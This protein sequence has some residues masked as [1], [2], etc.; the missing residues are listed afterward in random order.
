[1]QYLQVSAVSVSLK[2][3]QIYATTTLD[4]PWSWW[5]IILSGGKRL[6]AIYISYITQA[7]SLS[8]FS[9]PET[10]IFFPV[11]RWY[12]G[13][14][15]M[16]SRLVVGEGPDYQDQLAS[17][18][19]IK[20]D[21]YTVLPRS[22]FPSSTS[23]STVTVTFGQNE[24]ARGYPILQNISTIEICRASSG[25]QAYFIWRMIIK[26][27]VRCSLVISIARH[28]WAILINLKV[29]GH[30]ASSSPLS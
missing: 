13:L 17:F 30:G 2:T 5:M 19:P 16:N 24:L 12:F 9:W 23:S 14:S 26:V 22:H 15:I 8:L 1:M 3:W 28:R 21:P 18:I 6:G 7:T 27:Q 11:V 25:G 29:R 4:L 20:K 10:L